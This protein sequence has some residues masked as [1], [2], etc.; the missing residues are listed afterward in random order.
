[1]ITHHPS[2]SQLDRG[3][4]S[5]LASGP[6]SGRQDSLPNRSLD[7]VSWEFGFECTIVGGPGEVTD[8]ETDLKDEREGSEVQVGI[9]QVKVTFHP[10]SQRRSGPLPVSLHGDLL[11]TTW[12]SARSLVGPES[13]AARGSSKSMAP[14][15]PE[16]PNQEVGAFLLSLPNPV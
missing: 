9:C 16:T 6:G 3:P 4:H 11:L 2:H 5:Y 8:T 1:M 10:L 14:S 13:P 12:K 15:M 7:S